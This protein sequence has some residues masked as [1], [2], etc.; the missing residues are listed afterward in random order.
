[1]RA[2][3]LSLTAAVSETD[4]KNATTAEAASIATA[5]SLTLQTYVAPVNEEN[6]AS[7][8]ALMP[9]MR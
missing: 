1:M 6:G 3:M 8:K 4:A 9:N 2:E 5:L 7:E